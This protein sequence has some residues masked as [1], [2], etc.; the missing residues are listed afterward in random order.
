MFLVFCFVFLISCRVTHSSRATAGTDPKERLPATVI[1]RPVQAAESKKRDHD[2]TGGEQQSKKETTATWRREGSRVYV[3]R[4]SLRS[5][6]FPCSPLLCGC[7]CANSMLL[8][9]VGDHVHPSELLPG[10][11][12]SDS[13]TAAADEKEDCDDDE[14]AATAAAGYACSKA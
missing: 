6:T 11:R 7:V 10:S 12:A 2:T 3:L 13:A 5:R 8:L 1:E 4:L 14:S 9:F